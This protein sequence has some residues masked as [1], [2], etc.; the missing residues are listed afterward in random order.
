MANTYVQT[1]APGA[2]DARANYVQSPNTLDSMKVE[3]GLKIRAITKK[4]QVESVSDDI[5]EDLGANV[6]DAGIEAKMVPDAIFLKLENNTPGARTITIPFL[7]ALS[8][9]PT[10]GPTTPLGNE[11]KQN[12]KYAQFTYQEYSFAVAYEEWGINKNDMSVYG[13]FEQI[14]PQISLYMKELHGERIREALLE[15]NCSVLTGGANPIKTSKWNKNWFVANT[16]IDSQ[17][18]YDT[19]IQNFTNAIGAA[20]SNAAGSTGAEISLNNLRA[21]DFYATNVLRITPLQ[22]DGKN[23]YVV[24]IPSTQVQKLKSTTEGQLGDIYTGMV[25]SQGDEMK[26]TG[27]LGRVGN[28][29]LIEDQRYPTLDIKYTNPDY[30]ITPG[31][32]KPGNDD[33]R[34]KGKNVDDANKEYNVDIGFLLGKGAVAEMEVTPLHFETEIQDYG[35][36]RGTGAFGESGI[37][38]VEYD[39]DPTYQ[40]DLSRENYG[41]IVLAWTTPDIAVA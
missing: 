35:R 7:M 40:D 30:T 2:T 14:Q 9:A 41:S 17:P 13:V 29:L 15:T 34:A 39:L 8:G 19:T 37:S 25:R 23:S 18:V 22:L 20:I 31:Y 27:V 12:L 10:V 21:L 24:L 38:L 4:L 33:L 11:A 1:V 36:N 6:V 28:L 3:D 32:L 5:F 26:Y 16:D